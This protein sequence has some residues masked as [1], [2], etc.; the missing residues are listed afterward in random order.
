[1][2]KENPSPPPQINPYIFPLILAGMGIWCLYDGWLSSNPE[3][4]EYLLFNR[5]GGVVLMLWAT[6]DFRRTRRLERQDL[7][8]ESSEE[9]DN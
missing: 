4:Q 1:M 7:A 8:A 6:F 9:S 3:M 2:S 5:I